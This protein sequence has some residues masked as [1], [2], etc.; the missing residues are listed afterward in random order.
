ME[1]LAWLARVI[2]EQLFVDVPYIIGRATLLALTGGRYPRGS[3]ANRHEGRITLLGLAM[4]AA[5][6][7][8]FILWFR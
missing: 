1:R 5:L 6:A 4:I 7:T 2:A 8:T 3:T